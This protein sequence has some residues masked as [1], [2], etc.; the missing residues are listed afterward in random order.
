VKA[1][2]LAKDN[3]QL[4]AQRNRLFYVI[5]ISGV[6]NVL[7][8]AS[9][10]FM[11]GKERVIVVPPVVSHDFW[12]ATDSVSDSYLEQMT[13]FFSGL[14]LN[15]N[16]SSFSKRSEQ[17]L[18]HV[19]PASYGRVKAEM[20]EQEVDINNRALTSSFHPISFKVDRKN[21]MVEVKGEL[22]LMSGNTAIGSG[23]R[24]YQIQYANRNGKLTIVNFK[25][26]KNV[27]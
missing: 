2:F 24:S 10:Y 17:L 4:T 20:T 9:V 23:T 8:A 6:V 16:P 14:V 25:E 3:N 26:V 5:G 12:V 27:Q 13:S 21:L 15:V 1:Q 22:S 19:D 11:I 7:L 18:Q